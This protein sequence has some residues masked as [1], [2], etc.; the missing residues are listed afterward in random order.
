MFSL[1]RFSNDRSGSL[2]QVT[3]KG[4]IEPVRPQA[5]SEFLRIP[6]IRVYFSLIILLLGLLIFIFVYI[7]RQRLQAVL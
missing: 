2:S 1:S 4:N 7:R 6:Q 3:D 5:V